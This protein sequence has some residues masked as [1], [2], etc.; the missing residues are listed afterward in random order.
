MNGTKSV[1]QETDEWTKEYG[2]SEDALYAALTELR[3][4]KEELQKASDEIETLTERL[5]NLD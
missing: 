4:V 3:G 1:A 2:C 5:K